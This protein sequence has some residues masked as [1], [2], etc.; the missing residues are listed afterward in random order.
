MRNFTIC[1]SAL[2]KRYPGRLV[3]RSFESSETNE[4]GWTS[5]VLIICIA[6]QGFY[7]KVHQL[8]F[9]SVRLLSV[10]R[11]HSVFSSPP[12]WSMTS[13][14]FYTRSYTLHYFLIF[15][16]EKEPVFSLLNVEC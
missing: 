12:Q 11:G 6:V 5:S 13:E 10:L 1:V 9:F 4:S 15:I 7:C 2:V 8:F 16:T 14:D 3:Y